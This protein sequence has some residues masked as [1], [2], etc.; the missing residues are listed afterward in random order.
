MLRCLWPNALFI[1]KSSIQLQNYSVLATLYQK[2]NPLSFLIQKYP[3]QYCELRVHV[4]TFYFYRCSGSGPIQKSV[5]LWNIR[6]S[7][8]ISWNSM[9]LHISI[10]KDYLTGWT[11]AAFAPQ[12]F[13]GKLLHYKLG[14]LIT[15]QRLISSSNYW[16][17]SHRCFHAY[18]LYYH[19]PLKF[20]SAVSK[21]MGV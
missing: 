18:L 11:D 5:N 2:C 3:C 8:F 15:E 12:L 21:V 4:Y 6:F 10:A 14:S 7:K 20:L 1:H 17:F 13:E 19:L 16:G 9:F